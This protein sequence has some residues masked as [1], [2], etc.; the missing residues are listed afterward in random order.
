VGDPHGV[1]L[2]ADNFGQWAE[3]ARVDVNADDTLV[4]IL[5]VVI[6]VV[7][8]LQGSLLFAAGLIRTV[9]LDAGGVGRELALPF[10]MGVNRKHN[11]SSDYEEARE[12]PVAGYANLKKRKNLERGQK[13]FLGHFAQW[14][15]GR[16]VKFS[17]IK[18]LED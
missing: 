15:A 17:R 16:G 2:L 11:N 6:A 5:K 12:I 7:T 8:E 14:P 18:E 13:S 10:D 4:W 1:S 9:T 3:R